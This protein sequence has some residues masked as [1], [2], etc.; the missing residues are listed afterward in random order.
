MSDSTDDTDSTP[1]KLIPT[2]LLPWAV[3]L[4]LGALAFKTEKLWDAGAFHPEHIPDFIVAL[5]ALLGIGS[6]L[7]KPD[8]GDKAALKALFF[9]VLLACVAV[10]VACKSLPWNGRD[11]GG[12]V[13]IC[14]ID[15][16]IVIAG[17]LA[18][19]GGDPAQM[20][21]VLAGIP[22]DLATCAMKI[23]VTGQMLPPIQQP[24]LIGPRAWLLKRGIIIAP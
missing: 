9:P 13:E 17:K 18:A 20:D 4:V 5:G 2:W 10:S 8:G 12:K 24:Q 1:N 7:P 6:H 23:W 22:S 16:A 21:A 15:E 11:T 3:L 19:T 14:A